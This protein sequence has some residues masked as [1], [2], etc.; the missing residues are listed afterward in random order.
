MMISIWHVVAIVIGIFTIIYAN[1]VGK[2]V[3]DYDMVS[4][5]FG[6]LTLMGGAFLIALTYAIKGCVQ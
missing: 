1:R 6:L 5:I 2:T 3:G 4:P